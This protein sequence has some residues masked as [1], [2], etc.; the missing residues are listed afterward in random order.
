MTSQVSA[1]D[2]VPAGGQQPPAPQHPMRYP[3]RY[4]VP[5]PM[6][7]ATAVA[8]EIAALAEQAGLSV[9]DLARRAHLPVR[10]VSAKIRGYAVLDLAEV[11]AL[12]EVLGV[13][14]ALVVARA[15]DRACQ[16]RRHHQ[17][18][19][20]PAERFHEGRP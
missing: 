17:P 2:D 20:A 7:L 8:S 15:Q 5:G 9:P 14:P 1:G 16:A 11:E 10:S 19:D 13:D 4:P 18:Q 12:A 3:R 6:R